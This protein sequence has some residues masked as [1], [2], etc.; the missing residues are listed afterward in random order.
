MNDNSLIAELRFLG[1]DKDSLRVVMLLPLIQ[2]AWADGVIQN[3]ERTMILEI[4][5]KHALLS[6]DGERILEGWLLNA[7]SQDYLT[8]GRRCLKALAA[9]SGFDLGDGMSTRTL[10]QVL[11][12]CERVAESSGGLFGLLWSVDAREREAINQIASALQMGNVDGESWA[13][14][15]TEVD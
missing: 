6:E 5:S 10:A 14:A 8:R 9:R 7:P 12:M 13:E 15:P 2:V 11:E 3:A 4:A 1:I